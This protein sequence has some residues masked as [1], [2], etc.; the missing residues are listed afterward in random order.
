[1][2]LLAVWKRPDDIDISNLPDKFVIKAN[3]GSGDVKIITDKKSIDIQSIRSYFKNLFA[4]PF[5]VSSAEPH[6]TSIPPCII[7]EEL[8]D[9]SKQSTV[10]S[11]LIDYKIWCIHGMPKYI[12]VYLNRTKEKTEMAGFD[13]DWN[14]RDDIN[15]YSDH[16]V[17]SDTSINKPERLEQMLEYAKILSKPFPEVRVDFYEV[18]GKLYFGELTFTSSCGRMESFSDSAQKELGNLI[19]ANYTN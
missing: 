15:S 13:T 11:S 8:L 9:S 3:N 5:G 19:A 14:T 6:Y 18:D 1:M 2:P 4:H 16:F 17:P 10:S 12:K 7:A